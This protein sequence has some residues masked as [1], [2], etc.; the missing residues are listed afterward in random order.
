MDWS[1]A[2]NI[3]IALFL[4]LDLVLG[5]Y[6]F[7]Q[8]MSLRQADMAAAEDTA[9][10]LSER[11]AVLSC[12]IPTGSRRMAVLFV[13]IERS[14]EDGPS[15]YQGMP[16]VMTGSPGFRAVPLESGDARAQLIPASRALQNLVSGSFDEAEIRGLEIS[17]IDLV[18]W[19]DR[20]SIQ[21]GVGED[22][23]IP[24]WRIET[25]RGTVLVSALQ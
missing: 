7:G 15:E 5:V 24:A 18:Y 9:E 2:S 25:S 23:A 22:T 3:L 4:V 10:F 6:Y 19:V 17:S 14:E 20:S 12:D 1:K 11:G 16:L 8:Q 21:D 13:S